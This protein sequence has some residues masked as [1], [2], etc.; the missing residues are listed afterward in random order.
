M[1]LT[2]ECECGNKWT[3]SAPPQKYLQL[4]DNLETENFRYDG[5]EYD[6]NGKVNEFRIRCDQCGH[7]ISLGVD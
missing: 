1:R 6:K 5:A 2:I 7:Y 4:R 3:M